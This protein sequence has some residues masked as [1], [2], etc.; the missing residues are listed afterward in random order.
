MPQLAAYFNFKLVDSKG[1]L[2]DYTLLEYQNII[3]AF[4][5]R[6]LWAVVPSSAVHDATLKG[7]YNKA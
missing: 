5:N 4:L 1:S 6:E 7:M 3:I 2:S